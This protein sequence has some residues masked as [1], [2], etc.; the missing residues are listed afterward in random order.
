MLGNTSLGSQQVVK[1]KLEQLWSKVFANSGEVLRQHVQHG[2]DG[3]KNGNPDIEH[4][5]QLLHDIEAFFDI[6]LNATLFGEL[7]YEQQ[8]QILNAKQQINN[9]EMV[10]AAVKADKEEDYAS[11]VATLDKQLAI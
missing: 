4:R 10:A 11:A 1:Q 7:E 3:V 2:F 8:R 6:L 5:L 9:M